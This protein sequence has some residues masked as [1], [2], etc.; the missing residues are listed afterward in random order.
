MYID[1]IEA[2]I[3]SP[4][5]GQRE[6][7]KWEWEA[8]PTEEQKKN[9]NGKPFIISLGPNSQCVGNTHQDL[10]FG[11]AEEFPHKLKRLADRDTFDYYT[12]V[13]GYLHGLGKPYSAN[14]LKYFIT[15]VNFFNKLFQEHGVPVKAR[16]I[17]IP[18]KDQNLQTVLDWIKTTRRQVGLGTFLTGPGGHWMRGDTIHIYD[19]HLELGGNDPFGTCPY[20]SASQKTRV[21]VLYK[22]SLI[23]SKTIRRITVLEDHKW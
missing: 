13:N 5:N 10:L 21:R 7:E 4:D 12:W 8:I 6:D 17:E 19:D 15:H 11:V 14:D 9:L 23:E 2:K 20:K 1:K 22:D 18:K 16:G 3:I